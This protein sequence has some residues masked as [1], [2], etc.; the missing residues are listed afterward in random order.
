MFEY[1]NLWFTDNTPE[2][3]CNILANN[4]HSNNRI[5]I[6]LGDE[7]SYWLEEYDIM[8]YIGRSTGTKKIPL[9]LNNKKSI[10]GGGILTQCIQQITINKTIVYK[11]ASWNIKEFNMEKENDEFNVFYEGKLQACFN[12]ETKA[13]NYIEF[14]QGKRNKK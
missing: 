2:K 13:T 5:R 11:N 3:I 9:L 14:M 1:R 8:G 6:F 4:L 12:T 7:N 10:G